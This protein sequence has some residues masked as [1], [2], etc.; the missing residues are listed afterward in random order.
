M[1][2]PQVKVS[3]TVYNDALYQQISR[4]HSDAVDV[5]DLSS[6]D[7]ILIVNQSTLTGTIADGSLVGSILQD[8]SVVGSLVDGSIQGILEEKDSFVGELLENN[9]DLVPGSNSTDGTIQGEVLC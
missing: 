9:D 5:F 7:E 4:K 1:G 2:T 6:P 3:Y 8:T